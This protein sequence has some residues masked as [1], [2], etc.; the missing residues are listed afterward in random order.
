[1]MSGKQAAS[2]DV[3]LSC[4]KRPENA[5]PSRPVE[6]GNKKK[7]KKRNKQIQRNE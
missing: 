1:M 2:C 7:K 6:Y 4:G 3:I 5:A